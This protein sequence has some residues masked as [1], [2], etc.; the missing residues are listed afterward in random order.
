MQNYVDAFAARNTAEHAKAEADCK[1]ARAKL[2]ELR[3]AGGDIVIAASIFGVKPAD[4]KRVKDGYRDEKLAIRQWPGIKFDISGH[5][6]VKKEETAISALEDEI[7]S[8]C[9]R[10]EVAAGLNHEK[11]LMSFRRFVRAR[12]GV[13]PTA[14]TKQAI[15]AYLVS[16]KPVACKTR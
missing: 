2:K 11:S 8:C 15:D 1:A 9:K 4:V 14:T 16:L 10:E 7:H 12:F 6:A 13:K 5:A 3:D